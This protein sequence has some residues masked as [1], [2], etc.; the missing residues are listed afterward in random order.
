MRV[1]LLMN[2]VILFVGALLL[3][4]GDDTF[5]QSCD[6]IYVVKPPNNE[7]GTFFL[8][9][10]RDPKTNRFPRG[11]YI[12]TMTPIKVVR[13]DGRLAEKWISEKRRGRQYLYVEFVGS[14]GSYGYI[15]RTSI[16][17]L[18]SLFKSKNQ[19]LDCNSPDKLVIPISPIEDV[20]L[21]NRPEDRSVVPVGIGGFSRSFPDI[22][23]T[24]EK[25]DYWAS[26]DPTQRIPF[27]QVRF[28]Q[29]R[30]DG[31]FRERE[32]L[33][34]VER[35]NK[36]YRFFP[37]NP[38]VYQPVRILADVNLIDKLRRF[39][40]R[41][42]TDIDENQL[43]RGLGKSCDEEFSMEVRGEVGAE[44]P[45]DF[46]RIGGGVEVK[47][48]IRYPI[49]FRYCLDSYQGF[50]SGGK[51]DVLKTVRCEESS[52]TDWYTD[53]LTV[54]G[55]GEKEEIFE[56]FQHQLEERLEA[57]FEKPD[58]TGISGIKREKMVALR[59]IE[60]G[61]GRDYFTAF[62]KLGGYLDE[63]FFDDIEL[64]TLEK[65]QFKSLIM[66]LIVDCGR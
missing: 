31:T 5:A 18:V 35:E 62:S 36:T 54:T 65:Q 40:S 10:E 3:F 6:D 4:H 48:V 66:R 23:F 19:S 61:S 51:S 58:T 2:M 34:R 17:P 45:L 14:D 47:T 55:I 38:E 53:R 39:F 43:A 46:V 27:Y 11:G 12:Q 44:A 15:K 63:N 28:S 8:S 22:V 24:D 42:F 64:G 9:L 37:I 30:E 57:Y 29:E 7:G 21:F 59:E 13:K 52:T 26:E 16:T 60:E 41:F 56:I 20:T 25:H 50:V 1:R 33:I 49:G 32:A